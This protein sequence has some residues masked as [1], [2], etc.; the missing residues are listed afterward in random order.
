[1]Y[2]RG[3][4]WCTLSGGGPLLIFG[5]LLHFAAAPADV[6]L[7]CNLTA[8]SALILGLVFFLIGMTRAAGSCPRVCRREDYV[9]FIGACFGYI[10]FLLVSV[11]VVL[12]CLQRLADV[13]A[14]KRL[15]L[16][17]SVPC[18]VTNILRPK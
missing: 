1:M 15:A 8:P 18:V 11:V 10:G 13:L 14:A 16:I 6:R 7:I 17:W 9:A 2:R 12:P 5:V 3:G 4:H